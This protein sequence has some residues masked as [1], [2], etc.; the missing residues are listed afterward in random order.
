MEMAV[1]SMETVV[2]AMESMEMAPGHFLVPVGC[3]N[4]YFY[5]P[6]LVFDGGGAVE[7]VWEKTP[8]HL[9]FQLRRVLNRWRGGVRGRPGG[10]HNAH[11]V[12][13]TSRYKVSPDITIIKHRSSI[14]SEV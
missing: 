9:G 8:I 6:K 2:E 11:I 1:K 13:F 12:T 5:P 10:P 3:R 14:I 7:L 4:R